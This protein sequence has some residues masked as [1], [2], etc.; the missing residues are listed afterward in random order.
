[1]RRLAILV[2]AAGLIWSGH[3]FWAAARHSNAVI[4]W[5]EARRA[6]GWEVSYSDLSVRGFPNRLDTT[7]TDLTLAD[8]HSRIV[9]QMPFFQLLTLS[10]KRGHVIAVWPDSQA[11]SRGPQRLRIGSDGLRASVVFDPKTGAVQRTNLEAQVV[12]IDRSDGAA[13]ALAGLRAAAQHTAPGG[14]EYR[15]AL[16]ADAIAGGTGT[17]GAS[18]V[19]ADLTAT[20]DKLWTLSAL[21]T[22]RPQ[23]T[24]LGLRLMDY[25]LGDLELK[26]AGDLEIDDAGRADGRLTVKAA[27]WRALLD[28]AQDGGQIPPDL[29]EMLETGLDLLSRMSGNERTLDVPLRF[30]AGEMRLGP[31]PL[32]PAPR[33]RLP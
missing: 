2:I 12:N 7:L 17:P 16:A 27:N 33:L 6:D 31:V 9:W 23:P 29:A 18:A 20:F 4:D 8:P 22:P 24:R 32:G 10:Y 30:D 1:M 11:I 19:S 26:L 21:H 25:R 3:W 28:Q 14:T 13:I 5:L 15:L